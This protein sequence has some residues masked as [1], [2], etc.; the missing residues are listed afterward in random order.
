LQ[1]L[2]QETIEPLPTEGSRS[3]QEKGETPR[4]NEIGFRTAVPKSTADKLLPNTDEMMARANNMTI[5]QVGPP[6]VD[7]FEPLP[8]AEPTMPSFSVADSPTILPNPQDREI[9]QRLRGPLGGI[10]SLS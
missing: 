6:Q 7:V 2:T 1:G 3:Q 8:E 9:A 10:A 5:P 4:D